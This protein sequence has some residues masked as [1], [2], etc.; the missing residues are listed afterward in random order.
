M[1]EERREEG[2]REGDGWMELWRGQEGGGGEG[3]GGWG[4]GKRIINPPMSEYQSLVLIYKTSCNLIIRFDTPKI[5]KASIL[6]RILRVIYH[7][8]PR[9]ASGSVRSYRR[10]FRVSYL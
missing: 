9:K 8:V 6:I 10:T 1:V 5:L 3:R 4:G 7:S 2:G